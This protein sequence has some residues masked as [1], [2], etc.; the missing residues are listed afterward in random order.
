MSKLPV[1]S[2][3]LVLRKYFHI[4]ILKGE[5]A[6]VRASIDVVGVLN[7]E[8][9]ALKINLRDYSTGFLNHFLFQHHSGQDIFLPSTTSPAVPVLIVY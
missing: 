9:L 1:A 8:P 5:Y 7:V 4:P 6:W 2:A 3:L